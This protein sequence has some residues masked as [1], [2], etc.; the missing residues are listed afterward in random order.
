MINEPLGETSTCVVV[1]GAA[2][3][4]VI[5]ALGSSLTVGSRELNGTSINLDTDNNSLFAKKLREK[6][7]VRSLVEERFVKGNHTADILVQVRSSSEKEFTVETAVLFYVFD[8]DGAES[9]A[10][11][12]R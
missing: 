8:A 11:L 2:L 5:E 1:F 4:H 9:L 12:V 7:S 6:L 10:L 3:G